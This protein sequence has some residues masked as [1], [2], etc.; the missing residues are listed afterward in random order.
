M[1]CKGDVVKRFDCILVYGSTTKGGVVKRFDCILVYGSTTKGDIVKRFDCILD[2]WKIQQSQK[3]KKT[4]SARI[5]TRYADMH[6]NAYNRPIADSRSNYRCNTT[7]VY[8]S[9]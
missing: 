9:I 5:C 2:A 1:A 3:K 6:D 8:Q 4:T 7:I